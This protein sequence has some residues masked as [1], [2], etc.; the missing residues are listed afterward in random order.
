MR[1]KNASRTHKCTR[2][3]CGF[4]NSWDAATAPLSLSPTAAS[5]L[6]AAKA[7]RCGCTTREQQGLTELFTAHSALRVG[8]D[9]RADSTSLAEGFC[10]PGM[11]GPGWGQQTIQGA[12]YGRAAGAGI[13]G[14]LAAQDKA[15][16]RTAASGPSHCPAHS[17]SLIHSTNICA[18]PDTGARYRSEGP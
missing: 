2:Y 17:G 7:P 3:G 18:E 12:R 4:V 10:P 9:R 5:G 1:T 15:T 8:A 14:L 11:P 13:N 16:G 6:L